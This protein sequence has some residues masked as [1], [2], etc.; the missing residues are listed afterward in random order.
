MEKNYF[1]IISLDDS[2]NVCKNQDDQ[3]FFTIT[4]KQWESDFYGRKF[5]SL[6]IGNFDYLNKFSYKQIAEP[7]DELMTCADKK[8]M[9]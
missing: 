1:K 9:I 8:I 4:N 2:I 7:L 3:I 6:Q 5:G